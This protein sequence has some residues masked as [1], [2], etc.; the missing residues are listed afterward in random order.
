ML[1]V[2]ANAQPFLLPPTATIFLVSSDQPVSFTTAKQ[3]NQITKTPTTTKQLLQKKH[4][5]KHLRDNDPTHRHNKGSEQQKFLQSLPSGTDGIVIKGGLSVQRLMPDMSPSPWPSSKQ[6]NNNHHKIISKPQRYQGQ[7]AMLQDLPREADEQ[8]DDEGLPR[9]MHLRRM[10]VVP[11]DYSTF[12]V[13]ELLRGRLYAVSQW[14][15]ERHEQRELLRELEDDDLA[16]PRSRR[17]R[18]DYLYDNDDVYNQVGMNNQGEEGNDE[19]EDGNPPLPDYPG[20][21]GGG[22]EDGGDDDALDIPP[23]YDMSM[24]HPVVSP[25]SSPSR[26]SPGAGASRTGAKATWGS[27]G[28]SSHRGGDDDRISLLFHAFCTTTHAVTSY[29]RPQ[30]TLTPYKISMCFHKVLR[31]RMDSLQFDAVWKALDSN[32]LRL[33]S[34]DQHQFRALFESILEEGAV[35]AGAGTGTYEGTGGSFGMEGLTRL[36]IPPVEAGVG[37]RRRAKSAHGGVEST[38]TTTRAF[39]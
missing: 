25:S 26:T 11:S 3:I 13:L 6:K 27:L 4:R 14:L 31:I 19:E 12:E 8:E 18:Q 15:L 9:P 7:Q 39:G 16:S 34:I 29:S 33:S 35:E 17:R 24:Q 22:D 32:N 30:L 28:G 37:G 1:V 36:T 10:L 20:E 5:Q 2:G 38:A 21:D 23:D